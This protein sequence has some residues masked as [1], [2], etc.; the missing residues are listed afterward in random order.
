[1]LGRLSFRLKLFG[2][3]ALAMV[4]LA[5]ALT[6][7]QDRMLLQALDAQL[8]S[9]AEATKPILQAA[10]T[11]PLAERDFATIRAVFAE[12]VADEAFTHMVLLDMRGQAVASEGWRIGGD[13]LPTPHSGILR[14]S[15]G[16]YRQLYTVPIEIAGQ[17]LGTLLF[18]LSRTPIDAAHEALLLRGMAAALICLALLVPA[19][20]L[21]SRWLFRPLRRLEQ[22]AGAIR[23]G[24]YDARLT[25]RGTDDVARLTA[26][27]LDM[28][29]AMRARLLALEASEAAQRRLLAEAQ[30][31]EVQLRDAKDQAEVAT[32]AKS[33][34]LAN[35]SH[36]VRTPLNGILGMA[37]VLSDSRLSPQ[38]REA[39]QVI[40]ESG[41]ILLAVISDI[42]DVSRLESGRLDIEPLPVPTRRMIEEPL[43]PLAAAAL[44][45]GIGWRLELAPELPEVVV[46]DRTRVAQMLLNLA[47]NALKFTA[48]GEV[49]IRAGWLPDRTGAEHGVLR[50]QV[51]D[52]G[53]GIADEARPRVFERFGQAESSTTRRFGGSGLGLAISRQLVELMG[54]RIGFDSKVGQGSTFWF[55]IPLQVASVAVPETTLPPVPSLRVL[56]VDDLPAARSAAVALLRQLGHAAETAPDGVAAVAALREEAFDLVLLDMELNEPDSFETAR[57]IRALGEAGRI[58]LLAC[59]PALQGERARYLAAGFAAHGGKP[60]RLLDLHAAILDAAVAPRVF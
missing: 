53:I 21:G 1:M 8:E 14:M 17:S 13:P 20:E 58:P 54:G 41:R 19:V 46:A 39:V 38:D 35:I 27:F 60:V 40:L 44:R 25:P 7:V 37:Q 31:R 2:L 34:F 22:A 47:G 36:E 6:L 4:T 33:E 51:R 15:D 59:S 32:R 9:R 28:A 55:E 24:H 52:T 42:L 12:A 30:A 49:V 43:A 48:S 3:A 45:K 16:S 50:V 29:E 23:A 57:R 11:A 18:G 10:L 56:V 26:T 5:L